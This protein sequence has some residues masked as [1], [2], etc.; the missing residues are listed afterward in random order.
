MNIPPIIQTPL[1]EEKNPKRSGDE[2]SGS[3]METTDELMDPRK[4]HKLNPIFERE[5]NIA[6]EE[7]IDT[8][9]MRQKRKEVVALE[10]TQ[11]KSTSS[12][13]LVDIELSMEIY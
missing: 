9:E 7:I 11:H 2:A 8:E 13:Q 10:E 5:D 1:N 4:R 3:A 6:S 12:T